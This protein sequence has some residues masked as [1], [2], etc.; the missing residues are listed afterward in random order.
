MQKLVH[1]GKNIDCVF[2][3]KSFWIQCRAESGMGYP[4]RAAAPDAVSTFTFTFYIVKKTNQGRV[5]GRRYPDR[6]AAPGGNRNSIVRHSLAISYILYRLTNKQLRSKW[7]IS[8]FLYNFISRISL[9]SSPCRG[10]SGWAYKRNFWNFWRADTLVWW[11]KNP[12]QDLIHFCKLFL[13]E[14]M[15]LQKNTNVLH[16]KNK[17]KCETPATTPSN[18]S[19]LWSSQ[20]IRMVGKTFTWSNL[21]LRV[22]LSSDLWVEEQQITFTKSTSPVVILS[23]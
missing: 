8:N 23:R 7:N 18:K 12:P 16:K 15:A 9:N 4:D 11:I 1:R 22:I 14:K 3:I 6:A 5:G 13:V 2:F 21:L 17:F 20:K 19:V 10:R